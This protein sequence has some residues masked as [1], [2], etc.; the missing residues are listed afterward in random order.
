M[1]IIVAEKPSLAT[2]IV[3][4]IGGN[5]ENENYIVT[6]GFGHLFQLKSIDDYMDR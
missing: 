4:D 6:F 1:K 3:Q 2:T 5:F